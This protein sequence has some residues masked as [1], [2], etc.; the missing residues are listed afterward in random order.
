MGVQRTQNGYSPKKIMEMS[1]GGVSSSRP[2]PGTGL[3]PLRK[4]E[5]HSEILLVSMFFSIPLTYL[6]EEITKRNALRSSLHI[7]EVPSA[8]KIYRCLNGMTEDHFVKMITDIL[9]IQPFC[10]SA[11]SSTRV[12]PMILTF[13][14]E[15]LDELWRRLIRN[16]GGI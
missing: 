15:I 12:H 1:R 2:L 4:K 9:N 16:G 5:R 8:A 7:T 11:G 6:L 13:L 3:C 10:P 14:G